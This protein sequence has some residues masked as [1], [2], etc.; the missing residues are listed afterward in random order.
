M[1]WLKWLKNGHGMVKSAMTEKWLAEREKTGVVLFLAHSY[2]PFRMYI[3][4]DA[5]QC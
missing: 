2:M 4:K 1:E 5:F 3:G